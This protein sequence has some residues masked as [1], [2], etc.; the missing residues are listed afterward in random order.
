MEELLQYY[1]LMLQIADFI[2][3]TITIFKWHCISITKCTAGTL[4]KLVSDSL[5]NGH[6][7]G[8]DNFD[9]RK[10]NAHLQKFLLRLSDIVR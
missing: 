1:F 7:S 3:N 9:K 6:L 5:A 10:T 2:F 8:Q 4:I